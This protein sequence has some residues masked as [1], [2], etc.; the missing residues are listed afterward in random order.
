[1]F[2]KANVQDVSIAEVEARSQRRRKRSR[3]HA[4]VPQNR[5]ISGH[6]LSIPDHPDGA[7]ES[8][9][10]D[11]AQ[12]PLALRSGFPPPPSQVKTYHRYTQEG[13]DWIGEMEKFWDT[14]APPHLYQDK[15]GEWVSWAVRIC[16]RR[17]YE[18]KARLPSLL[19]SNPSSAKDR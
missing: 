18:P 3:Q 16:S 9:V 7:A 12:W 10:D 11:G 17:F 6:S 8:E 14:H 4:S 19:T 13:R 2:L 5:P 15:R 1:M